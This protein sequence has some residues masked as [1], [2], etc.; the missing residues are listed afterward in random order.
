MSLN[1]RDFVERALHAA[2]AA[3]AVGSGLK[4]SAAEES[5]PS[6]TPGPN[7]KLRVAVIGVNGQ[8]GSH[9]G[10]WL[11]NPDV[12]LVAVCDCDPNAYQKHVGKFK[13]LAH[14]PEY[15]QDVRKLLEK[16]DIDAVSIATPNHWNARREEIER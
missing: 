13:D 7:D 3:L 10:E 8:G 4:V 5:A 2:A 12:D 15:V 9:L 14:P 16:K 6:R 11:K 1:R